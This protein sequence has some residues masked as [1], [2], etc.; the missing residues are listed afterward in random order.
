MGPTRLEMHARVIKAQLIK[1]QDLSSDPQRQ[2]DLTWSLC[3]SSCF[4]FFFPAEKALWNTAASCL[5]IMKGHFKTRNKLH[6]WLSSYLT[7]RHEAGVSVAYHT[8]HSWLSSKEIWAPSLH[9]IS[10]EKEKKTGSGQVNWYRTSRS[11]RILEKE[12]RRHEII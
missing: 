9:T 2:H 6:P 5:P 8:W 3:F 11:T 12:R 7:N 1:Q 4:S 10:E